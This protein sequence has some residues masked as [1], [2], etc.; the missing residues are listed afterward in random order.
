MITVMHEH[1]KKRVEGEQDP[2]PAKHNCCIRDPLTPEEEA[3]FF[4]L[5]P[6]NDVEF[7]VVDVVK[8]FPEVCEEVS[9]H[10]PTG[11]P[12]PI[13]VSPR[14]DAEKREFFNE[15]NPDACMSISRKVFSKRPLT[16]ADQ[17]KREKKID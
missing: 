16:K 9:H 2:N 14:S 11:G 4:K 8:H 17:V 6:A 10:K 1:F 15:T 12:M 13:I 7:D 3:V 5:D